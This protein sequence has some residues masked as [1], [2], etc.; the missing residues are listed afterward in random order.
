MYYSEESF[1][2]SPIGYGLDAGANDVGGGRNQNMSH[3]M[4][5]HAPL[6]IPQH[7]MGMTGAPYNMNVSSSHQMHMGAMNVH[8]HLPSSSASSLRTSAEI[9]P[10]PYTQPQ[11]PSLSHRGA[12]VYHSSQAQPGQIGMTATGPSS[13][14]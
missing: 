2:G 6:Y 4:S 5:L 13:C 7:M 14:T 11:P 8:S 12:P 10:L 1:D 9:S 3:G